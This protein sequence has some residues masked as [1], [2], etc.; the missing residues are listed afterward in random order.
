MRPSFLTDDGVGQLDLVGGVARPV[1]PDGLGELRGEKAG[2]VIGKLGGLNFAE[3]RDDAVR[4][5]TLDLVDQILGNE[6]VVEAGFH[7]GAFILRLL[8]RCG[9]RRWR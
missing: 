8:R 6:I 3:K 4:L 2:E 9:R 7:G 5:L 1:N